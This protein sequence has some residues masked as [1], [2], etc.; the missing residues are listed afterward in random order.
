M[1]RG[2]NQAHQISDHISTHLKSPPGKSKIDNYNSKTPV[3][4]DHSRYAIYQYPIDT[5]ANYHTTLDALIIFKEYPWPVV[6]GLIRMNIEL[7]GSTSSLLYAD[8]SLP[9]DFPGEA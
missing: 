8:E 4:R 2:R 1:N 7:D 3:V 6:S 9:D 5:V